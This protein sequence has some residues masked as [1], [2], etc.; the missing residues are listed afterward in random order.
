MA[1]VSDRVQAPE[2]LPL[3]HKYGG[4]SVLH[5]EAFGVVA[6][7]VAGCV[8]RE[9][10]PAV[11]VVSAMSG[12][13]G[14]L[15]QLLD[16]VN[17]A[18]PSEVAAA[19]LT[20]GETV[21]AALLTAAFVDLGIP[22]RQ[23]RAD[24]IGFVATGPPE[25][26]ALE[27][28]DPATLLEALAQA[29][30]VVVPGGQAVDAT[31][32]VVMLGRNSSDLTAAAIAAALGAPTCE[33][34]S[35]VPGVCTA[36]PHLVPE[37]RTLPR[38]GYRTMRLLARSGAKVLH[39][40]AVAYAEDGNVELRCCSLLPEGRCATVVSDG[41]PVAAVALHDRVEVVH[42]PDPASRAAAEWDLNL[43]GVRPVPVE[44]DGEPYL[45]VPTADRPA[46]PLPG[47][48]PV[49]GA[50]LLTVLHHDGAV[51]R[52][53]VP[54]ERGAAEARRRHRELY[55]EAAGLAAA[56]AKT[57]SAHSDVL[58]GGHDGA[59]PLP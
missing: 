51:E 54:G 28:V 55:P 18:A 8:R 24:R 3:V 34:Y 53:L 49:P 38:I 30:V 9:G 37:A 57:R 12:T 46:A 29:P 26:A 10:R 21:S 17:P 15:Q 39:E 48:R 59:G 32:S 25:R 20:T 19:L 5:P 47:G 45:A 56:S 50:A 41:P 31:G 33:I 58:V 16:R 7:H 43:A 36:D 2:R 4:S 11:V 35:D 23:L 1:G 27:F 6:R 22:A 52:Q 40:G 42:F 13:T 44:V 14:R